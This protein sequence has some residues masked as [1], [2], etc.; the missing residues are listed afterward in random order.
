[1]S[2]PGPRASVLF[3][4]MGN[5]CRSPLAEG[6]FRHKLER[7]GL[8]AQFTVDSAGTGGWHVGAPPDPRS[9]A[10]AADN[11]VALA[12]AAR[13]VSTDDFDRFDHLIGMDADNC[14]DLIRMGAPSAKVRR[15]LEHDV[16]DPYYGGDDGFRTIWT[17][18]EAGCEALVEELA[19]PRR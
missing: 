10:I 13:R 3:V 9:R 12:G 7:R 5:I 4:C 8:G 19:A 16:P 1:M 15:L 11:G 18:I 6:V 2:A 17:L 14:R